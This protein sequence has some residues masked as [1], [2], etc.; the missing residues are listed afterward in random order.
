M[1]CITVGASE[2]SKHVIRKEMV[3]GTEPDS[4]CPMLWQ[5]YHRQEP[6]LIEWL[7]GRGKV[8]IVSTE[9][10]GVNR[11]FL[12]SP[13]EITFCPDAK[14]CVGDTWDLGPYPLDEL[15]DFRIHHEQTG[16]DRYPIIDGSNPWMLYFEDWPERYLDC[17]DVVVLVENLGIPTVVKAETIDIEHGVQ[18]LAYEYPPYIGHFEPD[19]EFVVDRNF[20]MGDVIWKPGPEY[21]LEFALEFHY[22]AYPERPDF[23]P[24]VIYDIDI[25]GVTTYDDTKTADDWK[26]EALVVYT[27]SSPPTEF[28]LGPHAMQT[29]LTFKDPEG[30]GL[31]SQEVQ[32]TFMVFF[33]KGDQWY[34]QDYPRDPMYTGL[35]LNWFHLW[36]TIPEFLDPPYESYCARYD[37]WELQSNGYYHPQ[38]DEFVYWITQ[39]SQRDEGYFPLIVTDPCCETT[40]WIRGIDKFAHIC[41]H[42]NLHKN[43]FIFWWG[44]WIRYEQ[45]RD[46]LDPDDDGVPFGIELQ[47]GLDP[48]FFCSHPCACCGGCLPPSPQCPG[49]DPSIVDDW[50]YL[51]YREH[52]NWMFHRWDY[53]DWANP[54]K[55]TVPNF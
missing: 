46:N 21:V 17:N 37:G 19:G 4:T 35:V 34:W 11:F 29:M 6:N 39:K 42:E 41:R 55:Q 43:Q 5:C 9:C 38:R 25:E 24:T 1:S 12:A 32:N 18:L 8:T 51:V 2:E 33:D 10:A 48:W 7:G 28:D 26:D 14:Y 52:E 53:S 23:D 45:M 15:L 49:D 44:T 22:D 13:E 54:G 36:K 50:E 31:G 20:P 16:Q 47:E 3:I 27:D 40:D 30:G